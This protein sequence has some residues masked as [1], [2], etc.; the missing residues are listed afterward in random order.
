[1]KPIQQNIAKKTTI[2]MGPRAQKV[3][4]KVLVDTGL[5]RNGFCVHAIL[6]AATNVAGLGKQPASVLDVLEAE[7]AREMAAARAALK[8]PG[9]L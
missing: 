2:R 3:I 7:F 9:V 4:D 5:S 6:I 1:M 8:T